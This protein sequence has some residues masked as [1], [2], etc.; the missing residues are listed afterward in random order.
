MEV[1]LGESKNQLDENR[2]AH[3]AIMKVFESS[4]LDNSHKTDN[5]K[6]ND[7]RDQHKRDLKGLESDHQI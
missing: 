3:D 5:V 6:L 4:Q 2:K 1:Q 7:L